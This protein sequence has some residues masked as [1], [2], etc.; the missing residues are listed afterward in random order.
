MQDMFLLSFW[1]MA[2]KFLPFWDDLN[3]YLDSFFFRVRIIRVD[4]KKG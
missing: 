1:V 4:R 3:R 2:K